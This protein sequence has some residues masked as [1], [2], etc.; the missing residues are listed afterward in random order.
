MSFDA[1]Q[2]QE[3]AIRALRQMLAGGRV[4]SALLFL[5]PRHVGKRTTALAL[6]MALNCAEAAGEGCG[7]CPAC[8]KIAEGVHPDVDVVAPDGQ[9]IKIDQVREV[10]DKLGLIPFE[11]RKRVIVLSQ[12]E[13]MNPPAANAFLKT[14]E[15]PPTDTL[16]VLCAESKSELFDTIVSRCLPVRF[17][18]LPEATLR[19]LLP[20]Q[21]PLGAEALAFA[22]RFAQGRLR[23]DIGERAEQWMAIRDELLE[24]LVKLDAPAFVAVSEKFAK[25]SGTGDWKFVLEWLETWF[26]DLALLGNGAGPERLMNEDRVQQMRAWMGRF[27]PTVADGCYR[28]VL[29][30]RHGAT[31]NANK[32]LGLEALWLDCKEVALQATGGA[33]S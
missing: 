12:A 30:A 29:E 22:V 15:E 5:G 28:R 16:I 26:R 11:A 23:P 33:A 8:R 21:K 2:G 4:P 6:A 25:W 13:R 14:L 7:A 20:R 1:I 18:R 32:L 19:E 9:F 10:V 27:P 24:E 3:Q 31:L 17:H